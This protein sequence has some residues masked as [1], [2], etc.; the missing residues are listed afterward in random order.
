LRA[1]VRAR[2]VER[3][4]VDTEWIE[5][6]FL[7]GFAALANAP[8]PELA[9]VAASIAEAAGASGVGRGE[10]ASARNG[11][12]TAADPFRASGRWRHPGLD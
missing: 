6:E 7:T 12:R 1:L 10:A 2:P 11:A 3:G 8:V 9:L 5:R 4:A